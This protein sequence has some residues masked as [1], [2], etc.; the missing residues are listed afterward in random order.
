[1]ARRVARRRL[2]AYVLIETEAGKT[3][4]VKKALSAIAGGSST[5]VH[6]DGVTGPFDFIAVVEGPDLD[7]VGRLVTDAIGVIDG[8]TRTT[9]CVAVAIG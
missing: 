8:V 9:T 6:V 1:M 2:K 7:A 5:V 3:R 4:S